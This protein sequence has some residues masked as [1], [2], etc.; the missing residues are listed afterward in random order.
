MV[1]TDKTSQSAMSPLSSLYSETIQRASYIIVQRYSNIRSETT[2]RT[3]HQQK[4][5][6][7]NVFP[8]TLI[9]VTIKSYLCILYDR[10]SDKA[11]STNDKIDYEENGVKMFDG[12]SGLIDSCC[13]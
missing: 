12:F 10:L 9:I 6:E 5:S 2:G 13:Y 4:T 3:L 7:Q 1:Y 8:P 11:K